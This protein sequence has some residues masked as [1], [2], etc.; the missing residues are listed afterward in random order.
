MKISYANPDKENWFLVSWALSNKC[1]YR[2]TYCP[3]FLHNGSSGQ[4][5]WEVVENFIRSL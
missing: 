5:K 3:D 1:N 2:C 4:P